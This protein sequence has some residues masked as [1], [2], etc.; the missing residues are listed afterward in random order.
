MCRNHPISGHCVKVLRAL[1]EHGDMSLS[2]VVEGIVLLKARRRFP[3]DPGNDRPIERIYGLEL[4]AADS[5]G[6]A[7]TGGEGDDEPS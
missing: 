3:G 5:H 7:E 1:A 2:D 6:L 4:G